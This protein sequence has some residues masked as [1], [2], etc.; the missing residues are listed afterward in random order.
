MRA[1][2]RPAVGREA[3]DV[4]GEALGRRLGQAAHVVTVDAIAGEFG[5]DDDER[6][7]ELRRQVSVLAV[8]GAEKLLRREIDANA[9]KVLLDELAAEI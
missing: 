2:D 3:G 1:G 9:H 6:R 4:V 8:S 7:E 5:V